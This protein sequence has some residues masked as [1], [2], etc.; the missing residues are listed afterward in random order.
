[1]KNWLN[2]MLSK[3]K[4]TF[5]NK[6]Y[7]KEF[8]SK[9]VIYALLIG[10]SYVFIYPILRMVFIS[11]MSTSDILDPEIS[12][13]AKNPSF[14]N[15][16]VSNRVMQLLPPSLS[17]EGLTFFERII[18]IFKDPGNLYKSARN[19]FILATIQTVITALAGFAFARYDFK[20]KK[21]LF[22]LVLISFIVP[23]PMVTIPRIMMFSNFQEKVWIPLYESLFDGNFLGGVFNRSLFNSLLPQI[24][25]SFLGQ[26]I[27]S[28]ILILI[29]YNFFKM[30]P[31]SLDEAAR[32]DGA[33][34]FQ[35]FWHIYVKLVVP[36]IIVVF[37]FAF[38]WN[39]NDIYSATIFY[40]SN[41]PLI[42][43]KLSLFDSQFSG[44]AGN[45]PGEETAALLNEGYKMAA[46]FLSIL[47]LL[48]LYFFAQNKFIEGI[49]RTGITGE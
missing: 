6:K 3:I 28:A 16:I 33:K 31:K 19:I 10:V 7:R 32:V 30:I 48:I 8:I 18:G 23:L 27:N 35:V 17:K 22:G 26:G 46:T 24:I 12:W 20:F 29:F 15:Y 40:S 21:L 43:S 37:L 47:P 5:A 25:L 44:A 42:V 14:T 38:I 34:P 1:M 9:L 11:L 2:N 4:K 45:N 49:E 39:W 41:N 36:I 13:I